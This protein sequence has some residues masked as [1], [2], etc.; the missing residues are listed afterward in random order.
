MLTSFNKVL[1]EQMQSHFTTYR[2]IPHI[3]HISASYM[4]LSIIYSCFYTTT[5][6]LSNSNTDCGPQNLKYLL[7]GP[8]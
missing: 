5:V 2:H 4:Y 7:P 8:L 3:Y 6:E 1:L